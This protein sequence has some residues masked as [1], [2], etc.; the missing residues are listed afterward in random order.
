MSVSLDLFIMHTAN[1]YPQNVNLANILQKAV[2]LFNLASFPLVG[3]HP[4]SLHRVNVPT[5]KNLQKCKVE[6]DCIIAAIFCFAFNS[7]LAQLLNNSS[8]PYMY[9]ELQAQ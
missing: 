2:I 4:R 7:T 1:S 5:T 6:R 8:Y 9:V 3:P